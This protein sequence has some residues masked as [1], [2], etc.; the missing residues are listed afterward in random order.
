VMRSKVGSVQELLTFSKGTTTQR[1]HLL[2]LC[3]DL[4][5]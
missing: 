1:I 2:A 3:D 4:V 5:G